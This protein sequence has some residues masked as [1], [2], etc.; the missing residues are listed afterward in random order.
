M[1]IRRTALVAAAA[2]TLSGCYHAV[3]ET[4]R[5][6]NGQEFRRTWAHSF[7][8]GL[9]PPST[10]NVAQQCPNGVARVETVH[11]FLN[12]LVEWVTFA[13]YSPLEI[14]VSCAGATTQADAEHVPVDASLEQKQE[15]IIAAAERSAEIDQPVVV[16]FE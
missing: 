8:A 9:I 3:V 11:S 4:G 10:V 6:P 15:A 14:R 12:L 2:V 7:I 13:I 16:V 5:P 1:S